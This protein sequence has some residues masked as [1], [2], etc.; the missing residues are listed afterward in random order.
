MA[1]LIMTIDSDSDGPKL[2]GKVKKSKKHSKAPVEKEMLEADIMIDT[3]ENPDMFMHQAYDSDDSD[4]LKRDDGGHANAWGFSKY[5][6]PEPTK[7]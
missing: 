2:S 7:A 4:Y 6:T 1:S 5:M 3:E